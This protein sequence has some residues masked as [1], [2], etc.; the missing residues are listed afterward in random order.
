MSPAKI[1]RPAA[2][3]AAEAIAVR[4]STIP[5]AYRL[6]KSTVLPKNV[7]SVLS[8]S[9]IL[10]AAELAI[11]DL[12]AT[13]LAEAIAARRCTAVEVTTAYIKAAAIAQQVTNCLVEL[14]AP[15]ALERAAFLDAELERT[16]VVVGAFHG[17]PVSIKDH[18]DVKGHDSPSGFLDMVGNVATRDAHMVEILRDA[19]AVF[20]CKTTNPQSLM[21]LETA[22][23]LGVTCSPFNTDLTAGGSSGGEGA[24]IGMKASPFGIGTD[25]GG[26]VRSVSGPGLLVLAATPPGHR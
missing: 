8:S 15:E 6:P 16:G 12:D 17:V 23:Y 2:E 20:Y 18:L 22:C 25:I 19:G 10:S 1:P 11:V 24:L 14:F 4:D 3:L 7:T 13:R 26:S 21:H 5:A 9:G